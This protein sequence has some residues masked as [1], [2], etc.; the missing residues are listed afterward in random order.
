MQG[1]VPDVGYCPRKEGPSLCPVGALV[2]FD[3]ARTFR[4]INTGRMTPG[5]IV[6]HAIRRVRNHQSG[7][8]IAQNSSNSSRVGAVAAAETMRTKL[9]NV[10]GTTDGIWLAVRDIILIRQTRFKRGAQRLFELFFSKPKH[11][12]VRAQER[13]ILQL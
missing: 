10:T 12:Q 9:P 1:A 13:K 7:L 4:A 8:L 3:P 6:I 11:R 5:W 2:I